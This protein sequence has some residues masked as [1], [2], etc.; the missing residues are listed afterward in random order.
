MINYFVT[1]RIKESNNLYFIKRQGILISDVLLLLLLFF[2]AFISSCKTANTN[3]FACEKDNNDFP[4]GVYTL[5]W[6][7]LYIKFDE[8]G[9]G[10]RIFKSY[11][12]LNMKSSWS[13]VS[14][15]I[16]FMQV[17]IVDGLFREFKDW[18]P[19]ICSINTDGTN[20]KKLTNGYFGDFNPTWVRNSEEIIFSR[21]D[22]ATNHW[23]I[24]LTSPTSCPGH[25]I[26]ISDSLFNEV[27]V[28]ALNDGRILIESDKGDKGGFFL[29]EIDRDSLQNVTGNVGKYQKLIIE[30]PE[31]MAH[32]RLVRPSIS[33]DN[34]KVGFEL[35][36]DPWI[37]DNTIL[38]LADLDLNKYTPRITGFLPIVALEKNY[39]TIYAKW[40][41]DGNSIIYVSNQ[42]GKYQFYKYDIFSGKTKRISSNDNLDYTYFSAQNTP[43]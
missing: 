23:G 12:H 24:Y 5:N 10:E 42:T 2:M 14:D 16:T 38:Y 31:N 9:E 4:K 35:A 21:L 39:S 33:P 19:I 41:N 43:N 30:I 13:K 7:S 6:R 8:K 3:N 36:E 40:T 15:K 32:L 17:S 11:L 22:Q 26:L 18:T 28:T 37:M 1:T 34:T 27:S 20:F 29:L 25:E